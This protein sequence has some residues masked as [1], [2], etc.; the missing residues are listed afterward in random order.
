MLTTNDSQDASNFHPKVLEF[1]QVQASK[2]QTN[3]SFV[4][5]PSRQSLNLTELIFQ[6]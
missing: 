1:F 6:L 4:S 2:K 3:D 5:I